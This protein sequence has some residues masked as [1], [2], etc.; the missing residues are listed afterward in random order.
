MS[1]LSGAT[2]CTSCP[3]GKAAPEGSETCTTCPPGTFAAGE[4]ENCTVCDGGY[5]SEEGAFECTQCANG[6]VSA[7][8][9]EQCSECLPGRVA[10]ADQTVCVDCPVGRIELAGDC[11]ICPS[12]KYSD[13][14]GSTDCT[15]CSPGKYLEDDG[16]DWRLHIFE[17]SCSECPPGTSSNLSAASQ[18]SDCPPGQYS[19]GF[20]TTQRDSCT[21]GVA[22]FSGSTSCDPCWDG[23]GPSSNFSNCIDCEAGFF[24][25]SGVCEPCPPG[26]HTD[27]E[28]SG[29]CNSCPGGYYANSNTSATACLACPPGMSSLSGATSCTSCPRGKAAPE[30]SETCT[31]CPPGTFAAGESENC[32]VCDGGYYS[33]EGAFECTQCDDGTVSADGSEQCS[34]CLPGKVANADQ[35]VCVDCPAGK[36]RELDDDVCVDC[37]E[38]KFSSSGAA[39]CDSCDA[40]RQSST[41][42]TICETCPNGTYSPGGEACSLCPEGDVPSALQDLCIGCLA[43]TYALPG[44]SSCTPCERGRFSYGE[45]GSCTDCPIGTFSNVLGLDDE[46]GCEECPSRTTLVAG[47]SSASDCIT[48][49]ANQ[50]FECVAGKPCSVSNFDGVG[51][52]NNHSLMVKAASCLASRVLS[53]GGLARADAVRRLG[54]SAAVSGFG[55]NGRS[56]TGSTTYTWAGTLTAA[57]GTYKVCWCGGL[58]SNCQLD[59]HYFLDA[60]AIVVAGPY[61]G[62][63]FACIKGQ[64]CTNKGPI[65]GVGLTVQDEIWLR[66]QCDLE[67][68]RNARGGDWS[69]V[70]N[71]SGQGTEG[72]I[73]LYI[74][75]A[76]E[77]G[78]SLM[79]SGSYSLCWCSYKGQTCNDMNFTSGSESDVYL[80]SLAASMT[81]EGPGTGANV[82][83]FLGQS[84]AVELPEEGAVDLKP[85]DT[86]SVMESCGEGSFLSGLPGTGVAV[87]LDGYVF[88]FM[89][90]TGSFQ[91]LESYPGFFR[92][93]W[94]R[95]SSFTQCD[96]PADFNVAAGLFVATGPYSGQSHQCKLGS[97]C[98]I[99]AEHLRGINL[100]S[101]DKL[102]PLA[103]CAGK[104]R[105]Q[106]YPEPLPVTGTVNDTTGVH[107]FDLGYLDL[108]DGKPELLQ[109]CWCSARSS[110]CS[111]EEGYRQ[112]AL[113][114]YIA[115]P[116]G[117]Y[118]LADPTGEDLPSCQECPIGHFCP[119]GWPALLPACPAG[120]IS[121]RRSSSETD[122]VCRSGFYWDASV[123]ACLRCPVGFYKD[124]VGNVDSCGTPCPNE[125]TS[126]G[127]AA[128]I[129]E[130]FCTGN[131]IDTD[132]ILETFRCTDLQDL[133]RN[134]STTDAFLATSG[135]VSSFMGSLQVEDASTDTL[136]SEI[137]DRLSEFLDISNQRASLELSVRWETAS[138]YVDFAGWSSDPGVAAQLQNKLDLFELWISFM[139][140][141]ALDSAQL[142]NRSEVV[143]VLVRCPSGLGLREGRHIIDSSDCMCPHGMQPALSG[144]TGLAAGC[145]P[146]PLGQYKSSVGD[147]SCVACPSTPHALTTLQEGSI[148]YAACTYICAAGS[149]N[150]DPLHP[151]SCSACGVGFYCPYKES[152]QGCNESQTTVGE[153][154]SSFEDCSCAQGF[155]HAGARVCEVCPA[156]KYK[157]FV[158]NAD[159]SNCSAG[160]FANFGQALC[161]ECPAGRFAAEGSASC[162]PCPPGR[163]STSTAAA[164]LDSCLLCAV[165]T[166]SNQTAA[167]LPSA[168]MPCVSGSTTALP[169][170]N[171]D[172]LCARPFSGQNRT[173]ISGRNCAIDGL[174]GWSLQDGHCLAITSS[175][176]S[177]A[178]LA[179]S[180]IDNNAISKPA[181]QNGER[182]EWGELSTDFTPL[183]G[184]YNL[185]WCA[186]LDVLTCDIE[187]SNFLILAGQLQVTGPSHNQLQCLRGSDCIGLGFAG[188]ALLVADQIAVRRSGCGGSLALGISAANVDGLGTLQLSGDHFLLGFG[189]S[190]SDA[191]YRLK[192]DA[193]N[194]GYFLC[195]CANERGSNTACAAADF[196]VEA[197]RLRVTGPH[198]NQESICSVGQECSMTGIRGVSMQGGD[199][200]MIL[201]DCGKG[202]AIPGLPAS[203]I[204]ETADGSTFEFLGNVSSVILSLPGIF[205]IC[206]CRPTAGNSCEST[207]GFQA[208]VGLMTATGPFYTTTQCDLG[209]NCT[210]DL[211]GVGLSVG[212]QL[213]FT[214]GACGTSDALSKLG[215]TRL[216]DPLPLEDSGGGLQVA[217]GEL[218]LTANPG[219][220]SICWCPSSAECSTPALFRAPTGLLQADCPPGTF[221]VGPTSG[222]R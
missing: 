176:C 123:G 52:V 59:D 65:F 50:S 64:P 110:N 15:E 152:R 124:F 41:D 79:P 163:Y 83:C 148:S 182:Y 172:V 204:L 118:E 179:V 21:L 160:T 18:C 11:E 173:C 109:V 35:T 147:T 108:S 6:T 105:S 219:L 71:V 117:F 185:C 126:S 63:A 157:E 67:S 114:L 198:F 214:S 81:I 119:G 115:C 78:G 183:G 34:E 193:S 212:D 60:G 156:G 84:C 86:V 31:T 33:E 32:T 203:G 142:V 196:A 88:H 101:G 189:V 73:D 131:S 168:C 165:G 55:T 181:T 16:T 89:E 132:P 69:L 150:D 3:R 106:A 68:A 103:D 54:P 74:S 47:S 76:H 122:C 153:S 116:P 211:S 149:F 23:S 161:D 139:T 100:A 208:R 137:S 218:P 135:N 27:Q 174:N 209:S 190:N 130:C 48:V 144:A 133:S 188:Y 175:S 192:I 95:P 158:G 80:E 128:N 102:L 25:S 61:E 37:D 180:N 70:T 169:G 207:L 62:Q 85:N 206:F 187:D 5:Y 14:P 210:L 93:C 90:A 146:C 39:S 217:L 17:L 112:L 194:A 140:G 28:G 46:L 199:R 129:W 13:T 22:Q 166:W 191:D 94:C 43:G 215:F 24:S 136:L 9:S 1:S 58:S 20:G 134:S 201:S 121:S 44:N 145:V 143:D 66:Q 167:S 45:V 178:I 8:G 111:V 30:G 57:P 77:M 151:S 96:Q 104:L 113:T 220:Y 195:W 141:T 36:N 216:K 53:G 56:G 42:R 75:M 92:L 51:L 82:E 98:E 97:Q 186:N 159:C 29:E 222:R 202:N 213:F 197:G 177:G 154:S 49:E 162:E 125:T 91:Y 107:Y 12:G 171:S 87:T 164:S 138:W 2:S 19:G 7:D 170:A 205:R 200:L 99:A 40:G 155:R 26:T 184:E 221:A 10:N 72:N 38:G 4:S 127:G 120:S